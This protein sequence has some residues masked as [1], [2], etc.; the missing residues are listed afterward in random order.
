MPTL[1]QQGLAEVEHRR[2]FAGD[3]SD[4]LEECGDRLAVVFPL[5]G[6]DPEIEKARGYRR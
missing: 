4:G 6:I 2:H 1:G 5:P 3:G